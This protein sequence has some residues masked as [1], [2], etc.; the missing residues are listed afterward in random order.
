M[1]QMTVDELIRIH[2]GKSYRVYM[3]GFLPGFAYIG[4]V[5]ERIASPR[6]DSPRMQVPAGSVGIAG[7]QT[8]IYPF[9]SPGGW[10]LIGQTPISLF[11]ASKED[12]TFFKP[13]DTVR[14][15]PIGLDEFH[16]LKNPAS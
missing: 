7:A 4:M 2:T 16:H 6:K 14:F 13:G 8:G 1:H 12:P 5:D 15:D 9:V 3:V 10:Q 11:D